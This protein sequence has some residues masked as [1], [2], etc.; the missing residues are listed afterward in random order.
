M[1]TCPR[2][3]SF[4][5]CAI[6]AAA[7]I[8]ACISYGSV[9]VHDG[10]LYVTGSR[11]FIFHTSFV[12]ECE[13]QDADRNRLVC[14]EQDLVEPALVAPGQL[15]PQ[16]APAPAPIAQ[17]AR[18]APPA[19]Q[20]EPTQRATPAAAPVRE[21]RTQ[22]PAPAQPARP[23]P[24]TSAPAPSPI[25]EDSRDRPSANPP[26]A[27]YLEARCELSDADSC[28]LLGQWYEGGLG[29]LEQSN[30][31]ACEEYE[32]ACELG[33]DDACSTADRWCD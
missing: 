2:F 20:A 33:H 29:G 15:V 8:P 9:A 1:N 13:T 22:P 3:F 32:K 6:L 24:A 27:N 16:P 10:T 5:A 19:R 31:R 17:P 7:A 28:F 4:F 21:P 14:V 23:R 26:S 18:V 25:P 11:G 12:L 30:P